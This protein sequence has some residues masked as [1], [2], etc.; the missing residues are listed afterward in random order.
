MKN[1]LRH[2]LKSKN[3]KITLNKNV[4][5]YIDIVASVAIQLNNYSLTAEELSII[6]KFLLD[7]PE[8]FTSNKALI[9]YYK[10]ALRVS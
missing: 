7:K 2:M 1:K 9:K 4:K 10:R 3:I 6:N 8:Y 5:D